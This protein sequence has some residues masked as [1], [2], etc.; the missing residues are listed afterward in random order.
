M[1]SRKK[2]HRAEYEVYWGEPPELYRENPPGVTLRR[3]FAG[4]VWETEV[5]ERARL[6]VA[7][8]ALAACVTEMTIRRWV[9][10]DALKSSRNRRGLAVR[11]SDLR[12]F[13]EAKRG[14]KLPRRRGIFLT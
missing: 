8:A 13:L 5:G 7:E 10:A 2:V 9:R 6:T 12:K 3:R 11:V 1:S 4:R 14:K